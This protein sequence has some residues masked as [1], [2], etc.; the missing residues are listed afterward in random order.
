MMT[1]NRYIKYVAA[2]ALLPIFSACFTGI[3]N[4]GRISDR[5]VA[6]VKAN[7]RTAEEALLDSVKPQPYG[8]WREGKRFLVTSNDISLVLRP[9]ADSLRGS[10]L[11]Y[12][13]RETQRDIDNTDKV[14]VVL[15]DGDRRYRY[16]TGRTLAELQPLSG[17]NAV[18]FLSDLDYVARVDSLLRGRTLYL[19]TSTWRRR[20]GSFE[21]GLR[22]VPVVVDSVTTGDAVYPF[23]VAFD[24]GGRKSG[25]MMSSPTSSVRNV[26]FDKLFSFSN[27]RDSYKHIPDERWSLIVQGKVALGMTKEE[28]TLS[29]G[30][31]RSVDRVPTHGGLV[32]RWVY[33]NG[34]YL[35]FND[36]VL[37]RFRQ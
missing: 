26:T 33:D 20:D 17:D 22:Y 9:S 2:L 19:R 23:Y 12:A 36:S 1:T 31:P 5:D 8:Q 35:I 10:T 6:R 34:V 7:K 24:C 28:C 14:V 27:I 32:E 29:L 18:P 15:A 37:E 13:G 25:V 21:S 30:A 3:E 16:E 4:T 11:I